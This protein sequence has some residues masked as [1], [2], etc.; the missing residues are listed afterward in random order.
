MVGTN[1]G[2]V[3]RRPPE[4]FMGMDAYETRSW[5]I[6]TKNSNYATWADSLTNDEDYAVSDYVG[7][8][9]GDIN[10]LLYN[11]PWE[12]MH[13]LDKGEITDLYHAINKFELHQPIHVN[14]ACDSKIF[15]KKGMTVAEIKAVLNQSDGYVQNDG[16]LSFSTRPEGVVVNS[17]G[18]QLHVD[19]P[20][21]KG[22]G[23]YLGKHGMT[24][25]REYL[26]NNNSVFK[27]DSNRV[28]RDKYGVIHV[29]GQWV[30]QAESQTISKNYDKRALKKGRKRGK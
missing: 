23:A 16:F 11:T 26:F 29:H 10:P 8:G 6:D 14:R 7:S 2:S 5:F 19:V 3:T 24:T 25:E 27:F 22:A 17:K 9:Y 13:D 20:E 18:V 30:G 4:E 21:N 15:G 1:K 28:Y 12:D